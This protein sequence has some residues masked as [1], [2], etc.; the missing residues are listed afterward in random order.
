MLENGN[1]Y[2]EVSRSG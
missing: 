1:I 2:D